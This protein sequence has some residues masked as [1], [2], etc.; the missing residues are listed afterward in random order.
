V[1]EVRN[2]LVDR[3]LGIPAVTGAVSQFQGAPAIFARFPAP[4]A[5]T[6]S[7][8]IVHDSHVDLPYEAKNNTLGHRVTHDIG[9]YASATGDDSDLENL[10]RAV[11]NAFNRQQIPVSGMVNLISTTTGAVEAP[12]VAEID[13]Q[14]SGRIVT[15]TLLVLEA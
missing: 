8:V 1:R 12:D 10:A 13:N 9:I 3:L 6:P 15:V 14:I 2:A 5:A 11:R 7:Y 4:P